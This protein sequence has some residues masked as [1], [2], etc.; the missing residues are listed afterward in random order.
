M[1]GDKM[2]NYKFNIY[3]DAFKCE[4]LHIYVIHLCIT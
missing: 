4:R 1:T 2:T 3:N